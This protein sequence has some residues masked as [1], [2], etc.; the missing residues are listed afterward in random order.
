MNAEKVQFLKHRLV[1][2]LR[3]IPSDTP[4]QWGKMS[5]QQMIEHFADSIRIASGKAVYTDLIT[6]PDQLEKSRSFMLS[7]KPFRENTINPLMPEMPAPVKNH[8]VEES[9]HELE[10]EIRYF[11]SVFEENEL[12]VTRN[13]FFCDLNYEEN[14]HLL[15][16]HALHHLSQLGITI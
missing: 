13:P 14:I 6:P 10:K 1:I 8:S 3:Q 12:R 15:Y 7:D 4:H 11:F 16:K 5:L 9:I 2:L